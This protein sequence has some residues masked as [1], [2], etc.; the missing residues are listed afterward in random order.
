MKL[1]HYSPSIIQKLE[2]RAYYETMQ[3]N[4]TSAFGKPCGLWVSCEPGH[5]WEKWCIDNDFRLE[6]LSYRYRVRLK[7]KA[8]VLRI[9]TAKELVDFTEKYKYC[10]IKSALPGLVNE[11]GFD[12]HKHSLE[13]GMAIRWDIIMKEYSGILIAPFQ[14]R[15]TSCFFRLGHGVTWYHGWDCASGCIWDISAIHRFDFLEHKP[16]KEALEI[17]D[18]QPN[19]SGSTDGYTT[20]RE[21]IGKELWPY[22]QW[23]GGTRFRMV[24]E[25]ADSVGDSKELP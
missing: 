11:R 21:N 14:T 15:A 20:D 18:E 22:S 7:R 3:F 6:H 2:K 16:L 4:P 24:Q 1:I 13:S 12:F 19:H 8:N 10:P 17:K 5:T 23:T 25:S 9:K